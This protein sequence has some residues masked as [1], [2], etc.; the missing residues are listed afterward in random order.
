M[1]VGF[2]W[3]A[4]PI[5]ASHAIFEIFV[6]VKH[7]NSAYSTELFC[8]QICGRQRDIRTRFS[9]ST[10]AALRLY[11]PTSVPCPFLHR[12]PTLSIPAID[13]VVK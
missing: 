3:Q 12:S 13:S 4:S 9:S 10:C 7:A 2:L 11:N 5:L 8:L 6:S 1:E